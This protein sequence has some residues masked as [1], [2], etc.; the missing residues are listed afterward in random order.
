MAKIKI[1]ELA[2]ELEVSS[3][4]VITFLNDTLLRFISIVE[5]LVS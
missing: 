1:H 5:V 3:K 4:E 2:K